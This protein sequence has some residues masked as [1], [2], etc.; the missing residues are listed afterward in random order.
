M[1]TSLY[2]CDPPSRLIYG[3]PFFS[4]RENKEKTSKNSEWVEGVGRV[5]LIRNEPPQ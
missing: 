5:H 4:R 2:P 3:I 1:K